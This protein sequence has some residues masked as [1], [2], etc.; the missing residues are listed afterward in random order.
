MRPTKFPEIPVSLERNTEVFRH[1]LLWALSP[2]L[3]WTGAVSLD[4][5]FIICELFLQSLLAAQV[6]PLS[7]LIFMYSSWSCMLSW[8]NSS[9][10]SYYPCLPPSLFLPWFRSSFHQDYLLYFYPI[11]TKTYIHMKTYIWMFQFSSV[12]SPSRVRLSASPWIAA[13][14]ASLSITSSRGSLRLTSI[15]SVMPSSHLILCR[16]L[17]LLPSIPPSIR[18]FSNESTLHM[19]WPKY[20]S[21]SFSIIEC[22][23]FIKNWRQSAC[24]YSAKNKKEQI[25]DEHAQAWISNASC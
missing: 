17:F 23:Q 5:T 8:N 25:A 9:L 3:I 15:E 16:P 10:A 1:P 19:R 24:L 18:V 7:S 12:Q 21:F 6:G 4:V 11:E 20:W 13:H 22:L 14:Q 2:L